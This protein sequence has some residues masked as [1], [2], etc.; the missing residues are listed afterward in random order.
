MQCIGTLFFSQFFF[1]LRD[2]AKQ[3]LQLLEKSELIHD[4]KLLQF[5][6]DNT[7]DSLF[8]SADGFH[9]VTQQLFKSL[10]VA[11]SI[12]GLINNMLM[13]NFQTV[14]GN[15]FISFNCRLLFLLGSIYN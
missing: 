12:G 14:F 8:V 2:G 9:T 1:Q 3:L 10:T 15:Q 6:T 13:K 4:T 7:T 11:V 5:Q